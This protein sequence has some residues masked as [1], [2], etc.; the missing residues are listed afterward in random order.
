MANETVINQNNQSTDAQISI[1]AN[2]TD[3]AHTTVNS[4]LYNLCNIPA[5][6]LLCGKY[7]VVQEM[8]IIGR[9]A[10]LFICEA[11]NQKYVAKLYRRDVTIKDEVTDIL[12][13]MD[14]PFLAKLYDIGVYNGFPFEIIP[15]YEQGALQGLTFTFEELKTKIIPIL[16]EGLHV[17]HTNGIIHKYLKPSNIMMCDNEEDVVIIDFGIGS[18]KDGA[19]TII[20]T[21]TDI[22]P[23]YSAPET[24][25]NLFLE[26]ADYYS[27]GITLYELFCGRT[28]YSGLKSEGEIVRYMATQSIPFPSNMPTELCNLITGLTYNDITHRK[29]KENPNR[30]WTYKE[31]QNW[32]KGI[33]QPIPG[34]R[35]STPD[36]Q[37]PA[38]TFLKQKY[39]T[40]PTLV[41]ALATNWEE[42]KKRLYRGLLSTF[43]K[44]VNPE[45]ASDCMDAEETYAGGGNPD[46]IFFRTIY[47]MNPTTRAFYWRGNRFENLLDLGNNMLERLRKHD[48]SQ[49]GL[50]DE[51]LLK[52]VISEYIS[53]KDGANGTLISAAKALEDRFSTHQTDDRA[54]EVAYYLTGFMLS[55]QRQLVTDK[56]NA[57]SV[58]D[59]VKQLQKMLIAS[60]KA[61]QSVCDQL[62]DSTG[63]LN[64][65]FEAWL[66]TLGKHEELV[67]WRRG[68]YG[69]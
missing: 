47:K 69:T 61:F 18:V 25:W 12:K 34:E 14:S 24:F 66:M 54:K 68:E 33:D 30:R 35:E 32:C 1:T 67:K 37:I 50:Y 16:N 31:V 58:D 26:E 52:H 7:T 13:K 53:I 11:D 51:I 27:L 55:G 23:E 4:A 22:V 28:P 5:G 20:V 15:Y 45:V 2:S 39:T 57:T 21:P 62:I 60:P 19:N 42:G 29:N 38:Y 9:K 63:K 41:E 46:N 65:Q 40:I 10:S 3:V 17:L 48:K 8:P 56:I 44:S 59:L 36:D 43:F 49:Y 6:T 64:E